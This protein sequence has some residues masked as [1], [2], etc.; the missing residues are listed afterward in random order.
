MSV[1]KYAVYETNRE[2]SSSEMR[3]DKMIVLQ[4][5]NGTVLEFTRLEAFAGEFCGGHRVIKERAGQELYYIVQFLN[6]IF[7]DNLFKYKVRTLCEVTWKMVVDF[8]DFYRTKKNSQG[9]YISEQSLRKCVAAV[10]NFLANYASAMGDMCFLRPEEL[11]HVEFVRHQGGQSKR[12]YRPRY[13]EKPMQSIPVAKLRDMTQSVYRILLDTT[14]QHDPMIAFAMESG[15]TAGLRPSEA[16]NMR[17]DAS[18]VAPERCVRIYREGNRIRKIEIDLQKEYP[19]RSDGKMVG[20]IKRERIAEVIPPLVPEFIQAYDRHKELLS[21]LQYEGDYAPMFLNQNGKAM[22]YDDYR[23]RF[24]KIVKMMIPKLLQSED[25]KLVAYGLLLQD[26]NISPH[27]MRHLFSVDLVL[28]GCDKPQIMKYRGDKSPESAL[29]Y[30]QDKQE[31]IALLENSHA[32]AIH[33]LG[34]L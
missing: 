31:L 24:Q 16:M 7:I 29:T 2:I 34:G 15:R 13:Q 18:K 4:D 32:D 3:N 26:H 28:H 10:S 12:Q 33:N 23:Y 6:F 30:M 20:K 17:Q 21:G 22:T 9:Q 27:I 5:E 14:Y 25:D 1:Q 11:L 8:F 19:L